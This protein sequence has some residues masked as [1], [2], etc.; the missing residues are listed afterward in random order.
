MKKTKYITNKHRA[1]NKQQTNKLPDI[2]GRI[3]QE[4]T[5]KCLNSV[6]AWKLGFGI[7]GKQIIKER[8]TKGIKKE[9]SQGKKQDRCRKKP[10]AL[11]D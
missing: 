7:R 4:S 8:K 9:Q 3:D 6:R 5:S 10:P 11:S 2:I 1:V